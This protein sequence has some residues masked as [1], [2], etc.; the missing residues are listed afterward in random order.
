MPAGGAD[1]FVMH[2]ASEQ[3]IAEIFTLAR[4]TG[5]KIV[6][7]G[8]GKSYGDASVLAEGICISFEKM[9][10]V[11][12]VNDGILIAEA[13]ASLNAIWQA[14]LPQ[15]FWPPVVTGTA[16]PTLGGA[17]AMNVHGKNAYK[18][19]TLGENIA[20]VDVMDTK[21]AVHRLTPEQSDF[22]AV[23][24][25]AGLVGL[26][27]RA[28]IRLKPVSSGS[29][30]VKCQIAR[31]WEEHFSAFEENLESD[32]MVSWVDL[33]GNGRGVFHSARQTDVGL[34]LDPKN[35][36]KSGR[37]MG[38]LP[39]S[40]AWLVLKAL[41]NP[42]GMR[43]INALKYRAA[44]AFESGKQ[45]VQSHGQFHFLLDSIPGWER[46]Y[47]PNGLLQFQCF[48]PAD[49]ALSAFKEIEKIQRSHGIMSF[50]GVLKR[51]RASMSILDYSVDGY[52]LALDFKR[53]SDPE[54]LQSLASAMTKIVLQNGGKLYFAK[55]STMTA[56]E[57]HA[58]YG[59]EKVEEFQKVRRKFDPDH[60]LQSSLGQRLGLE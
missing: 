2:P 22:W 3:E 18:V 29:L 13:G 53:S 19:G 4:K 30:Q 52:S 56:D 58:M 49:R 10:T 15:G 7:R 46:A 51:H 31:N 27:L 54:P 44:Q 33:F 17:L 16:F 60:L 59:R 32:Y 36:L 23:I 43:C 55:D 25:G 45:T 28:A 11:G 39:R 48:I 5:R 38:I 47:E 21:G 24:G 35:Q 12:K 57:F 34:D 42:L 1:S 14:S 50:L 8:S 20:W 26:I 6:L 41:N 9:A 37:L 40:K